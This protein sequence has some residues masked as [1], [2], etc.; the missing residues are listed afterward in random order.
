MSLEMEQII[1]NMNKIYLK[2]KVRIYQLITIIKIFEDY[3]IYKNI[4]I[5]PNLNDAA[6]PTLKFV[7]SLSIVNFKKII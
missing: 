2:K 7:Q 5:D 1:I 4:F 3:M 6:R